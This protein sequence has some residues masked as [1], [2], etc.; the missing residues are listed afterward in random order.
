M[1]G[2]GQYVGNF[3]YVKTRYKGWWGEGDTIFHVDGR[4][5][6]HSPGTE[7]EY[8]SCWEFGHTYSYASSGYLLMDEGRNL[9]YRWYLANP[10]R[11]QKSLQ[12]LI[13]NQRAEN[14][15]QVPGHDDYTSVAFWYQEGAHAAP[16][17]PPYAERVAA[18]RVSGYPASK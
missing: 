7:D 2:H 11:F 10:V 5:Q 18:S 9:M 4:K 15:R 14:S 8:G 12:V 1:R 6:T 13:Q 16:K 17:L 3:L